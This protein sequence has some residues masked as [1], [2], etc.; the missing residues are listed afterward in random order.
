MDSLYKMDVF[1]SNC[2]GI[3]SSKQEMKEAT[4]S[5]SQ[6]IVDPYATTTTT[7]TSSFQTNKNVGQ[8]YR[9]RLAV[10]ELSTIDRQVS[11]YQELMSGNECHVSSSGSGGSSSSISTPCCATSE[12]NKNM[13]QN[14][15]LDKSLVY[16]RIAS[17][18]KSEFST[19]T[20]TNSLCYKKENVYDRIGKMYNISVPT[21]CKVDKE[22]VFARIASIYGYDD[23]NDN[24]VVMKKEDEKT[25]PV[26]NKPALNANQIKVYERIGKIYNSSRTITTLADNQQE[27][28][29]KRIS[30][31]Y[32][33]SEMCSSYTVK[34]KDDV[35]KRIASLYRPKVTVPKK[36]EV[37]T[38]IGSIYS[39]PSSKNNESIGDNL[40]TAVYKRVHQM[41]GVGEVTATTT[42]SCV[43]DKSQVYSRVSSIYDDAVDISTLADKSE[44]YLRVGKMYNCDQSTISEHVSKEDVYD[45]IGE[46]YKCAK[47]SV[48]T[49]VPA[50]IVVE[51]NDTKCTKGAKDE[52]Y[53]RI[54]AIYNID[55][56]ASLT[57]NKAQVYSRISNIYNPKDSN[58][59]KRLDYCTPL[60]AHQKAVYRRISDVY[61]P[62]TQS[63]GV[64]NK[65]AV[66][67]R[68]GSIFNSSED[69]AF[70][71]D[72]T[73]VYRR[74]LVIYNASGSSH[75]TLLPEEQ[76]SEEHHKTQTSEGENVDIFSELYAV[77]LLMDHRKEVIVE[78]DDIQAIMNLYAV[79]QKIEDRDLF[80]NDHVKNIFK[81]LVAMDARFDK[82]V[83]SPAT[84]DT[85]EFIDPI[86]ELMLREVGAI[87]T[88]S[89]KEKCWE[90]K[91]IMDLLT[92][93]KFAD[94]LKHTEESADDTILQYLHSIDCEVDGRVHAA[95]EKKEM[96]D[97]YELFM[98]DQEIEMKS[99]K[100][101]VAANQ[102]KDDMDAIMHLYDTDLQVEDAKYN[103]FFK[104]KDAEVYKELFDTDVQVDKVGSGMNHD[105]TDPFTKSTLKQHEKE[106]AAT[107]SYIDSNICEIMELYSTDMQVGAAAA[108]RN[109]EEHERAVMD[110]YKN[111]EDIEKRK[112]V[113]KQQTKKTVKEKPEVISSVRDFTDKDEKSTSVNSVVKK[114][115]RSIFSRKE[116][117]ASLSTQNLH[118]G[119]QK[120]ERRKVTS[121]VIENANDADNFPV[122]EEVKPPR[123]G[124]FRS[125]FTQKEKRAAARADK[126]FRRR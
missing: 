32:G 56:T 67:K 70:S 94:G 8:T 72:K 108:H 2:T 112:A 106:A 77:D 93:D 118:D 33:P 90:V 87:S 71:D 42:T 35:Y 61:C 82:D 117:D 88:P 51:V 57:V 100:T 79:D 34:N 122:E 40:A 43:F 59:K 75:D 16:A 10:M 73:E 19:T 76:T 99:N 28:V 114:N 109:T 126:F 9:E 46:I 92:T 1:I 41:Y 78:N 22:E 25:Y 23:A 62:G 102:K 74:V 110:L 105:L 50:P 18:Y 89:S 13:D 115:K 69:I 11:K 27:E 55:S 48:A 60:N 26:T 31:I 98:L 101:V 113:V 85:N 116:M 15:T 17:I 21:E 65:E 95:E 53:Q 81:G 66:Y 97:V 125:I 49:E 12:N 52:V 58:E 63:A 91:D 124:F 44:V 84:N 120:E 83:N 39:C 36:Q 7:T 111:D 20:A 104:T 6:S 68:V 4:A 45:R 80:L 38:R 29:Y 54:S 123:K 86:T 37:Y 47:P 96:N 30:S 119:Y 24:V 5:Y 121:E 103:S 107:A 14:C 64:I 3:D